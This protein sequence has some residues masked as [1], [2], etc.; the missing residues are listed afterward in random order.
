VDTGSLGNDRCSLLVLVSEF[1]VG[2]QF[3]PI[4]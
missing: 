3:V 2:I 4:L 1:Q